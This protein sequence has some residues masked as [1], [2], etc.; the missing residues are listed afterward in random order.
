MMKILTKKSKKL[1][2]ISKKI[3]EIQKSVFFCASARRE[4]AHLL[5]TEN[6]EQTLI[7]D[8]NEFGELCGC[9]GLVQTTSTYMGINIVCKGV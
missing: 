6:Q 9:C 2:K 3:N 4:G 1:A 8:G 7:T 5:R